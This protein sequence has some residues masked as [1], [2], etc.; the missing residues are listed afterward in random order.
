M[1]N[2]LIRSQTIDLST[3]NTQESGFSIAEFKQIVY[4][5][6]KPAVA[7]GIA[8]F[9][10]I[11]LFIALKTPEYRS[12]TLILL[13]N[14]QNKEAASVAPNTT[15]ASRY[16]SVTDLS[17]E[18]FVLRSNSMVGKAIKNLKARYPDISVAEVVGNLSIYQ[19]AVNKT[20]T[21]VLVVS[22]IDTDPEKAKAVLEALG[23]TYINYSLEKQRL[24][25]S[26]AIKFIDSQ[27]PDAQEK[28]DEAAKEIRQFRQIHKLV[29]PETSA[30]AAGQYKQDIALQIQ[31][32]Q[33]ALDLNRKQQQELERL[34]K[35]LG[36]DSETMLASSVL[37]EDGV[38]QDLAGK[39]KDI[40]TQYNLGTVDYYDNFHVMSNLKEK[41]QEL[42]QLLQERAEQVLGKSISPE[43]LE[44]IIVT[45]S[46]TDAQPPGDAPNP[47]TN[48]QGDS[49]GTEVSSEGSTL[50]TLATRK[51]GLETEAASLQSQLASLRQ[52]KARADDNFISIPGLQQT[53][54]E[55]KRQLELKSEA[56][57]YLLE[58]RQELEISEAEET[59]PWRILNEPFLPSK[60][61]APNIQQGLIQALIAGG[62]IGVA[63]A[64]ILQQLDQSIKQVEEI[65]QITKLPLLGVIPKVAEP[66]IEA[67]IHT[68]RRSYSYYSSFTEGL[69]SLAMNLRYLM[70][71]EGPIKTLA[72]TSSTSA[73]GKS[74]I[75]YNLAI[76]LAELGLKVLVVDGDLR[77]P[78]LHK[79]GQVNNEAGLSEAITTENPWTDYLQTNSID[80]LDIL[81]AG[82]TS[83]NPIALLN[84]EKMKRLIEQWEADYDYVI[85]DTPPIGVIADAK[86]LAQ[87]VDSILFIAGIQ[88]ASRKSIDN[89]L[90]ILRQSQC[91]LAG[92]VANL[93]DPEFDYYAYS[94]Y[95]S[96][97]NQAH[98]EDNDSDD[99]E[100]NSSRRS[101]RRGILEQFRR[102]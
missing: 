55:L 12:E 50:G 60:P 76:V 64:F 8:A 66:R 20:P 22:Y 70:A 93:V 26:N 67:N 6:W 43:V 16:Y 86:S 30:V 32:T 4:R 87:E 14:S 46:Y 39:L 38:Y 74:T 84:S 90:D 1:S 89:A 68:T 49:S 15:T 99:D 96:Y 77:K 45:P 51:L 80:N 52:E 40:E 27:L 73:E 28:L 95:D 2:E 35:E 65:K 98:Q 94:Y 36:Q 83:P 31:Q 57:N 25:A 59:A 62:F 79:L 11:F 69:R 18:I 81:T 5:R 47:N 24:Q 33:I 19:A 97:Y 34:L 102:R 9:T 21:D 78:R 75:S 48:N 42:K 37:G 91:H 82:A 53:F 29:D 88:R 56:Y 61:I 17:T 72:V 54:T 85:I 58:R 44:R 10:G 92:V 23:D 3:I 101:R 100:L 7:M 13:E 71:D 41:R 63:T